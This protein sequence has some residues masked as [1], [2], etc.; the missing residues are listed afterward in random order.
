MKN[1][2]TRSALGVTGYFGASGDSWRFGAD[3]RYR[4]WLN[5]SAAL[6]FGPGLLLIG[7]NSQ[8]DLSFPGVAGHANL[9]LNEWI[10][11]SARVEV[12][13]HKFNMVYVGAPVGETWTEVS[14]YAGARLGGYPGLAAAG[15]AAVL[16]L[17]AQ[18]AAHSVFD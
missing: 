4:L 12:L 8:S 14:W 11:L 5:D 9:S 15:A 18:V 7:G 10:G 17:L 16:Y 2:D 6:D 3:M 1:L 13:G